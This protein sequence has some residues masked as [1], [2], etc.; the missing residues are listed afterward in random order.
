MVASSIESV[1]G[2]DNRRPRWG[3]WSMAGVG[4]LAVVGAALLAAQPWFWE[5]M[6]YPPGYTDPTYERTPSPDGRYVAIVA[7]HNRWL[8]SYDEVWITT[9]EESDPEK[10]H[11][12]TLWAD[13]HVWVEWRFP[14]QLVIHDRTNDNGF[15][16]D[17]YQSWRDVEI[18]AFYKPLWSLT[19][20]LS[21]IISPDKRFVVVVAHRG[22]RDAF[23]RSAWIRTSD[24]R[25]APAKASD[26]EPRWHKLVGWSKGRVDAKWLGPTQLVVT[27]QDEDGHREHTKEH[28]KE[29]TKERTKMWRGVSITVR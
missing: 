6:V 28:T 7:N 18:E 22:T 12:L 29:R 15:T 24:F 8:D 17:L 20:W 2:V 9:A 26:K 4:C 11:R 21:Q 5:C 25:N 23:Y 3:C 16:P 27:L 13:G 14:R 10:W 1:D 19:A